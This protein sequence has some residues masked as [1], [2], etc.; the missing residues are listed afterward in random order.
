MKWNVSSPLTAVKL[1]P[2]D[3]APPL[4]GSYSILSQTEDPLGVFV[5][6]P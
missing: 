4:T 6:Q 2:S 5:Y 3:K 1:L